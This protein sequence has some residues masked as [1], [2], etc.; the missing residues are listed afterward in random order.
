MIILGWQVQEISVE[1][2]WL[3]WLGLA[4]VGFYSLE[5]IPIN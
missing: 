4:P 1:H 3:L 2:Y 5:R